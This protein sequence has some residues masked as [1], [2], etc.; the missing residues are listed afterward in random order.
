ME[1]QPSQNKKGAPMKTVLRALLRGKYTVLAVV[2]AVT[3]TSASVALAGSGVNGVF[4]LGVTNTVNAITTLVSGA[5]GVGPAGPMLR[6]D[7]NSTNAAAT[8]LELLVEPGKAPMKVN[9]GTKVTNL[10]ADRLDGKHDNQLLRVASFSGQSPLTSGAAGPVA[11]TTINAPTAGFLVIDAGVDTWNF[12]ER[13]TVLCYIQIDNNSSFVPGSIRFAEIN[14]DVGLN[15]DEDCSTNAVVPVAA[16]THTVDFEGTPGSA[17]TN[18]GQTAL[19]AIYVPFNGTGA[20]PSS[21]AV[22][23]ADSAA[24]EELPTPESRK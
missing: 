5:A 7:N 16:G 4:N 24:Q 9:S 22:T 21:T 1:P 15:R 23:T 17:T 11:T 20:P 6:I 8:A 10:N 18:W 12:A 2:A 19:S 3:L 14:G 13:A